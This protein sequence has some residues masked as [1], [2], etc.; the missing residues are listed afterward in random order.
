M[1]RAIILMMD[2]FGVGGA[3][4]AVSFGDAGADTLGHIAET[5]ARGEADLDGV[6]SGPL[7][8]PNLTRLGLAQVAVTSTGKA[9]RSR[10][11][12]S[13]SPPGPG[14]AAASR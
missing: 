2:S 1:S 4:D 5:C 7:T 9:P 6:R 3:A 12:R 10:G 11:R 14:R 13:G 8:L